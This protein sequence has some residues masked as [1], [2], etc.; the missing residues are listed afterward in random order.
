MPFSVVSLSSCAM[1]DSTIS[2][3]SGEAPTTRALAQL[4]STTVIGSGASPRITAGRRAN[5]WF[6][7][8]CSLDA[9]ACFSVIALKLVRAIICSTSSCAIMWSIEAKLSRLPVINSVLLRSSAVMVTSR[10]RPEVPRAASADCLARKNCSRTVASCDARACL[11]AIRRTWPEKASPSRS[12]WPI[13]LVTTE[14][15]VSLPDTIRASVRGSIATLGRSSTGKR[16]APG[17]W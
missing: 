5:N 1:R 9:V 14:K 3:S 7:V 8:A 10:L 6:S 15:A 16:A 17:P 4:S 2:M 13:R 12:S 11:S